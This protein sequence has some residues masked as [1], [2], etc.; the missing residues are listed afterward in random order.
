MMI[1]GYQEWLY[2]S[3]NWEAQHGIICHVW[4]TRHFPEDGLYKRLEM[5][6]SGILSAICGNITEK[7][8]QDL[9]E[10]SEHFLTS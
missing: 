4:N 10:K 5:D 7:P 6:I 1:W 3:A 9:N 8:D 2:T